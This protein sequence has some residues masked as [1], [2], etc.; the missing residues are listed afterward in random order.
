[1]SEKMLST[2]ENSVNETINERYIE[3]SLKKKKTHFDFA[4]L[5][6]CEHFRFNG[7]YARPTAFHLSNNKLCTSETEISNE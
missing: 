1:M 5:V 6:V 3:M 7:T 4:L 2:A